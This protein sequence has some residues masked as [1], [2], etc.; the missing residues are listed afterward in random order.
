MQKNIQIFIYAIM[1]Q[2]TS[3]HWNKPLVDP[4]PTLQ[5]VVVAQRIPR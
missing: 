3:N 4:S 5:N 1:V 2:Y